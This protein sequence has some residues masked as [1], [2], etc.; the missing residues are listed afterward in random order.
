MS[1]ALIISSAFFVSFVFA[2]KPGYKLISNF[3]I[4]KRH[5]TRTQVKEFLDIQEE[6]LSFLNSVLLKNEGI[7]IEI[8]KILQDAS[9]EANLI[10]ENKKKEIENILE[11]YQNFITEKIDDQILQVI[12]K[13]KTDSTMIAAKA[14]EELI[15]EHIGSQANNSEI[16]SSLSRDLSK[17]LH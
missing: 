12:Q 17:K 15:Q 8:K 7:Q 3:L 6:S 1:T 2:Y 9:N 11:D 14:V 10:I 16:V 13:L 4:K 5:D